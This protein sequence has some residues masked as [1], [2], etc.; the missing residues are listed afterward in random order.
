[1]V[2]LMHRKQGQTVIENKGDRHRKQGRP[3][4]ETRADCHRKQGQTVI[5]NKGRPSSKT[6]AECHMTNNYTNTLQLQTKMYIDDVNVCF[7]YF[8][9][10]H[11]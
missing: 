2:I 11:N 5:A 1:M 4:S 6:R 8:H 7:Q 10:L 9:A 3:S